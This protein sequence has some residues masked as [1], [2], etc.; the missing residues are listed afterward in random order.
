MVDFI[1]GDYHLN[2]NQL[3]KLGVDLVETPIQDDEKFKQ[4]SS[5]FDN[6]KRKNDKISNGGKLLPDSIIKKY[7]LR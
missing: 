7:Q 4:L 6:F 1:Q 5:A 2:G 3:F